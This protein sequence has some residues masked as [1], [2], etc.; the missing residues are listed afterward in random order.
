MGIF[1]KSVILVK[2]II[3]RRTAICLGSRVA[4]FSAGGNS[5]YA[6]VVSDNS[7]GIM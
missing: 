4:V 5:L 1:A 6:V 7:G 2:P 3:I